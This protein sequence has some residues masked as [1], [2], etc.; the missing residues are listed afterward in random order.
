MKRAI[1]R[2]AATLSTSSLLS[3]VSENYGYRTRHMRSATASGV[4]NQS[5]K[6]ASLPMICDTKERRGVSHFR[7]DIESG[8]IDDGPREVQ[9]RNSQSTKKR[10]APNIPTGGKVLVNPTIESKIRNDFILEMKR[11]AKLRHPCIT[12][13]MGGV[14]EK[15]EEPLLVM[16]YMELGSLRDL[17]RNESMNINGEIILP[18]LRDIVQGVRFLH[19]ATPQIV[20][21]DLKASNVLVDN[22]YRAK[23][24]DFGLSQNNNNIGVGPPFWM[25]PEGKLALRS[26]TFP[27]EWIIADMSFFSQ[28]FDKK[29]R[30]L[31]RQTLMPSAFFCM[32]YIHGKILMLAKTTSKYCAV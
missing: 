28:F 6:G 29:L 18:I 3:D 12:T 19:A 31:P 24:A 32:K 17:L 4:T 27:F 30:T 1:L 9:L 26:G 21:A 25:A 14:L 8:A 10:D 15:N 2:K 11:L 22:R 13:L 20:H 5:I 7:N 23:V 16:E